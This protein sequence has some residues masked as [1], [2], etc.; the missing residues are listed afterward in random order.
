[1]N[2]L[3][4][5]KTDRVLKFADTEMGFRHT[6]PFDES[7]EQLRASIDE[8]AIRESVAEIRCD[9]KAKISIQ[10]AV[11]TEPR[12]LQQKR[13]RL[14]TGIVAV[15]TARKT[16]EIGLEYSGEAKKKV[17]GG[18]LQ[19]ESVPLGPSSDEVG[20]SR[21][22][23]FTDQDALELGDALLKLCDVLLAAETWDGRRRGRC[24]MLT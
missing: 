16:S 23:F 19:K 2:A 8:R 12:A 6:I 20:K 1:M 22:V 11:D 24:S 13:G 4:H 7:I 21:F 14:N 9:Q 5:F 15:L 3:Q 10:A 17:A 18:G